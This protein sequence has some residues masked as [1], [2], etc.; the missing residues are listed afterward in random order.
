MHK[1]QDKKLWNDDEELAGLK[2]QPWFESGKP[3]R[4]YLFHNRDYDEEFKIIWGEWGAQG[5][6]KLRKVLLSRPTE[7]D[8]RAIYDKE[9]AYYRIYGNKLPDFEKMQR[10]FESF[11]NALKDEDIE[12][13]FWEQP[14]P[15]I[16]PYGYMR[17][18]CACT[19]TLL[20]TKAGA[21]MPR[22]AMAGWYSGYEPYL[23]KKLVELGCPILH[24]IHGQGVVCEIGAGI[25]LD[26]NHLFLADGITANPQGIQQAKDVLNTIGVNV[27][28]GH[29]PGFIDLWGYPA[30]GVSHPDMFLHM[31]DAGL[32]LIY[33]NVVDYGS[34][35]YLVDHKV[36][37]I[38]GYPDEF[39][40]YGCNI[41][42]I[43]PG[44]IIIPAAAKKAIKA[45]RNAGVEC[46]D[47]DFSE[48]AKAGA[49]GPHCITGRLLR[50]PG[51][52][53]E[54]L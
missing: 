24:S 21:I 19:V 4:S 37:L 28:V 48:F 46:I 40:E 43:E 15:A 31:V 17:A 8:F 14:I 45:L 13:N 10:Q 42:E 52:L 39:M 5:I 30:G 49:G 7:N 9:P 41:L 32:A 1:D 11:V 2:K 23:M 38:E 12:V 16:G 36:R 20:V 3:C 35:E 29:S 22:A 50:D 33:P 6:G 26:D 18:L 44:K 51:P 47:L 34:I 27:I 53:L 25:W 54:D